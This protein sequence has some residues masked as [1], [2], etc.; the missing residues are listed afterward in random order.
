MAKKDDKGVLIAENAL[1]TDF[2]EETAATNALNEENSVKTP[3]PTRRQ[4][5]RRARLVRKAKKTVNKTKRHAQVDEK[6]L[7]QQKLFVIARRQKESKKWYKLDNAALMY[8]LVARGESISVFRLAVQLQEKVDPITLQLAVN[9]VFYRFPSI[10]GSVKNGFFWPYIDR[11]TVPLV[12]K[13]QTKVPGRPMPVDARHSQI[14]VNYFHNQIAVEFFHSA[15]DGT[16]G[17]VFLNSLLR[18]YFLRKGFEVEK[19]NCLDYRDTPTLTE[20]RDN[21]A[22]IAVAKN[23]PPLPPIIKSKRLVGTYFRNKKYVT[24]KGICS[25]T[26]L[27]QLA[28]SHNATITD[29]LSAVQL[30]ALDHFCQSTNN[31]D[32]RPIRILIPVNL[33]RRYNVETIRNF[34]SYIFY[35]YNGQKDLDDVIRDIQKQRDEQLTDD[36]FRGMVS[37]NYNSGNNPV[38]KIVPLAVK[39]LVL[40]TIVHGRGD[41][42]VN[43]STLSNLGKVDAPK[44]FAD[45]VIRYEFILGRP[46]KGTNNFTVATYNDVCVIAVTNIFWER[47]CERFFFNKLAEMGIDIALESDIWEEE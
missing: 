32:P 4:R 19:R 22:N 27:H 40:K 20:L 28:K 6:H 25:A 8:P 18:C 41:G 39:K 38:L 37:Y 12:V 36:Y 35:Q 24:V 21:F 3:T 5:R 1:P 46:A 7:L 14:R 33:R 15:T 26:Q 2:Q 13:E 44:E 29:F 43:C 42:I 31:K 10:C 30:L 11:P 45:K 47:D 17:L 9:D 16:G 23:P 34:S